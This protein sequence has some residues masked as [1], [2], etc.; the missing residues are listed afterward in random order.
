[1]SFLAAQSGTAVPAGVEQRLREWTRGFRRVRLRRAVVVTP[2]DA[3]LM[4]ELGGIVAAHGLTTRAVGDALV[5]MLPES[6]GEDQ[7]ATLAAALREA[8]FTPQWDTRA[9]SP[10]PRNDPRARLEPGRST[11][12]RRGDRSSS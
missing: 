9:L 3:A 7:E 5:V 4:D 12:S 1:L 10:R 2:D 11:E 8:G 6:G